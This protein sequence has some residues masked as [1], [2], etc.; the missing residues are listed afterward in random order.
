MKKKLLIIVLLFSASLAYSQKKTIHTIYLKNGEV[1]E[2]KRIYFGRPSF[3]PFN[4]VP[5]LLNREG[6]NVKYL[7]DEVDSVAS[8]NNSLRIIT[9]PVSVNNQV[10][11]LKKDLTKA[12]V[13][14][15]IH[16]YTEVTRTDN[17]NSNFSSIQRKNYVE[18]FYQFTGKELK[19]V[20]YENMLVDFGDDPDSR[21]LIEKAG[22]KKRGKKR[23]KTFSY[24]GVGISAATLTAYVLTDEYSYLYVGLPLGIVGGIGL[25]VESLWNPKYY[26]KYYRKAIMLYSE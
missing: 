17:P 8:I 26:E 20:N 11:W 25:L 9:L 15:Y 18:Y 7:Y 2:S 12:N 3:L 4:K 6:T 16:E 23:L 24:V 10:L 14:V 21:S 19:S 22:K 5:Y 1:I 13:Q